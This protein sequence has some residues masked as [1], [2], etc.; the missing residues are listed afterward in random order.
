MD[1]TGMRRCLWTQESM[2]GSS[3]QCMD[4]RHTGECENFDPLPGD[5]R[6]AGK[7]M[8]KTRAY[9]PI[10]DAETNRSGGESQL[11]FRVQENA[12]LDEMSKRLVGAVDL[13]HT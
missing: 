8:S 2:L 9:S 10:M 12:T 5:Y 11:F 13:Q 7:V 4:R 1:R 6:T 3:D